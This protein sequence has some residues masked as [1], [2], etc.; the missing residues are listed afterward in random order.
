[1]RAPRGALEA[2]IRPHRQL[3]SIPKKACPLKML[4]IPDIIAI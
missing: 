4:Y 2:E 3:I 1:L